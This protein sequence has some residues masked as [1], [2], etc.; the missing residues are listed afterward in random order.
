MWTMDG[1]G[2]NQT[3][4]PPGVDGEPSRELHG[5]QRWFLNVVGGQ[6]TAIAADGTPASQPLM[7]DASIQVCR[8]AAWGPADGFA[9]CVALFPDPDPP[10]PGYPELM[11]GICFVQ[12]DFSS[13][14]PVPGA[15]GYGV[16]LAPLATPNGPSPAIGT[17][18]WSAADGAIVYALSAPD[19]GDGGIWNAEPR[20]LS[21]EGND[22]RWSPDGSRIAFQAGGGDY[23]TDVYVMN[24]DGSGITVI[25]QGKGGIRWETLQNYTSARWSPDPDGSYLA[26]KW[27]RRASGG[28]TVE[29]AV[30]RVNADGSGKTD[31]TGDIGWAQL[32]A[33]R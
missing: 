3:S 17:H 28:T 2:N 11:G 20:Q 26:C 7:S 14:R 25:L 18:D 24:A 16:H 33:W 19:G 31:L 1:D 4:L 30:Y 22:P 23:A 12:I 10:D 21:P 27:G 9:S 8:S 15:V 32:V 13:G 6:L 29:S 5:G